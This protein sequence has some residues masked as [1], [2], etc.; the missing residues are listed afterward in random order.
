MRRTVKLLVVILSILM[1]STCLAACSRDDIPDG[2]QLIAR[3]GD[4]FRLYVPTAGW[5]PNT[6]SG[7]TSAYFSMT[8]QQTGNP[9]TSISVYTPSDYEVP[10]GDEMTP[11]GYWDIC[12]TKYTEELDSYTLISKKTDRRLGRQDAIECIYTFKK[13]VGE[14]SLT[15]KLF[16]LTTVYQGQV[17][18]LIY[19]SPESDYDKYSVCLYG[20]PE[21]SE[22]LGVVGFFC[23]EDTA[24]V[25]ED[26]DK[27]FDDVEAPDGMKLVSGKERP[28]YLFAPKAWVVDN[29]AQITAIKHSDGSS[30]TVN[31]AMPELEEI[32]AQKYYESYLE[33]TR[34]LF[35]E[36]TGG[37]TKEQKISGIDGIVWE[38]S[39]K[40]GG[41]SYSF[42]QVIFVK[43]AVVYVLTYTATTENYASHLDDVDSMVAEFR[44]K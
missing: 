19:S 24:Y 6:S 27:K 12:N 26:G 10:D 37:E 30:V 29:T 4:V 5:M 21:N 3:E 15:Y 9:A 42:K 43:G 39:G 35:T 32:S 14:E 1:I 2:Y 31:M 23:F 13:T 33:N 16:Q 22:D 18:V 11:A 28:Y 44:L 34:S 41:V 7:V 38:F 17:Y 20:D 36:F 40:S 8:N 25:S